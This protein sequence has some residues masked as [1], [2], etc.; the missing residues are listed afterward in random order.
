MKTENPATAAI[1]Y[2]LTPIVLSEFLPPDP[3]APSQTWGDMIPIVLLG[4]WVIGIGTACLWLIWQQLAHRRRIQETTGTASPVIQRMAD[5]LTENVGLT[6]KPELRVASQE[7]AFAGPMVMGLIRPAIILPESFERELTPDQQRLALLHELMHIKRGDL[8]AASAM[9]GFRVLNWPNPL[10]H[11]AWPRFRADQE[12]ACDASVLRI[13]GDQTR[14]DYAETLL[15]AAQS[16][17]HKPENRRASLSHGMGLS[18]SLHHPIKERLMILGSKKEQHSSTSRWA[19]AATLMAGAALCAPISLAGDPGDPGPKVE[20]K[21]KSIVRIATSDGDESESKSF[22]VRT[23]DGKTT[24]LRHNPDGTTEEVTKEQMESEFGAKVMELKVDSNEFHAFPLD[25]EPGLAAMLKGEGGEHNLRTMI[26]KSG[27]KG[28]FDIDFDDGELRIFKT[29]EN[30]ERIEIETKSFGSMSDG[31]FPFAVGKGNVHF[32]SDEN[33]VVEWIGNEG[34]EK[35]FRFEIGDNGSFASADAR[36][37]ST[38]SMLKATERMISDLKEDAGTD[39][40]KD[41]RD[42]ER[43]LEKARKALEKAQAAVEKADAR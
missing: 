37:R 19:L 12:A 13:T 34:G 1:S 11:S 24:Y 43:Q 29:D 15:K 23:E 17:T 32:F 31:A 41:L 18:L 5:T 28:D 22:E 9:M 36:L 8:W 39:A 30:G 26:M 2:E 42:A 6:R 7:T 38:Q 40:Q 10:I 21:E 4:L 25:G 16:F 33:H 20:I 14:A 27:E 3:V 35:S